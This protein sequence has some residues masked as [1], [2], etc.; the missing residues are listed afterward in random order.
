MF[1][2]TF[3]MSPPLN[4]RGHLAMMLSVCLSDVTLSRTSGLS[5]EQKSL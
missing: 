3:I 2:D 5:Q 1:N 4:R